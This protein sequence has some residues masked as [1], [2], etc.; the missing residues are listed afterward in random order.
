MAEHTSSS[1]TIEA[2]PADV[3]GVIADFARYPEWTGEVKEAEV[4]ATDDRGPRRA[5]P[6]ASWTPAPSRTTTPSPTPGPATH[7]VSWTLVKS[8]MLRSL[9]GSYLLGPAG[10]RRPHRGH[11]PAHRRR[12][13]PHARHD[14]AQGREGHHRPRPGRPE[15][16]RRV[17]VRLPGP[18]AA[19]VAGRR[20]VVPGAGHRDTELSSPRPGQVPCGRIWSP[21]PAA[22]AAPRSRRRPRWPPPAGAAAPCCSPPTRPIPR[23][24]PRHPPGPPRPSRRAHGPA[25]HDSGAHFRAELLALQDQRAPPPWTCS[26]RPRWTGRS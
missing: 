22:R 8:Q 24:R 26:A 7:E 1:I 19:R 18:G 17:P 3:M 14:Q 13:D 10:R 2:A 5:G 15:E 11:L 23:R 25:P 6:A 20:A 9:D 16:A 12:Q 4:L 21:A